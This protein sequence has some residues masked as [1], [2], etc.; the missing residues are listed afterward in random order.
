MNEQFDSNQLKKINENLQSIDKKLGSYWSN[1]FKG[2]L[3]GLG[4]V[5]GA[6]LAIILIGWF[7]TV[8]GV[9][10]ALKKTSDQWRAAI[11]QVQDSKSFVPSDATSTTT[12]TNTAQ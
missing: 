3:Y 8:I 11:Q 9:I 12:T 10:P 6:G 5:V 1:L 4:T 2:L 7:L